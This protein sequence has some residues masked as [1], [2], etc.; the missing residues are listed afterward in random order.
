MKERSKAAQLWADLRRNENISIASVGAYY[1]LAN[2]KIVSGKR[3]GYYKPRFV[4]VGDEYKYARKNDGNVSYTV[5][6]PDA[7]GRKVSQS[8][9]RKYYALR[10]KE[11]VCA[12]TDKIVFTFGLSKEDAL[13]RKR[14]AKRLKYSF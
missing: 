7:I 12:Q 8:K 5:V 13:M 6:N 1:N 3:I 14:E 4:K 2:R 10:R 11:T 9:L